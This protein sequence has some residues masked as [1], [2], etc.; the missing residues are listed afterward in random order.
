MLRNATTRQDPNSNHN[1]PRPT[2]YAEAD[3]LLG[4]ND[5]RKI[6]HNTYLERIAPDEIGVRFYATYIVKFYEF[7]PDVR[8]DTGG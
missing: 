4:R 1:A 6:G 5:S 2:T 8:V 3:S 7:T